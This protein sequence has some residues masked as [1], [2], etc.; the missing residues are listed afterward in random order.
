[1]KHNFISLTPNPPEG[2]NNITPSKHDLLGGRVAI[3]TDSVEDATSLLDN[4]TERIQGIIITQGERFFFTAMGPALWYMGVPGYMLADLASIAAGYLDVLSYGQSALSEN[5]QLKLELAHSEEVQSQLTE[6]YNKNIQRLGKKVDQ[7]HEEME[8]SRQAEDALRL[9][10]FSIEHASDALFWMTSDGR[11]VDVNEA[12]CRTLGYTR[13]E[14]MQLTM[15]D[16][17]PHNQAEQWSRH[18]AELR[19]RGSLQ[20]ESEQRTKDGRLIPVEIVANHVQFGAEERNCAFVRDTTE[21]KL[22][23]QKLHYLQNYLSN[24]INSMPSALIGVDTDGRVTQWNSR[25]QRI[26]GVSSEDAATQPLG[27]IFPRLEKDMKQVVEAMRTRQ[28]RQN[29]KRLHQTKSNIGYEDITIY[30][31]IA[32]GVDGAVIRIDDVTEQVRQEEMLVQSEKMLS[33]GGLAA[34]MAHEINNPLAGIIQTAAVMKSRLQDLEME[35]NIRVANEIGIPMGN[36]RAF[37]DKRNVFSMVD[38]ISEACQRVAKIVDNMLSFAR[39]SDA[40]VSI[41]DPVQLIDQVIELASADYDLKKQYD[42]KAIKIVKEYE[43]N[44]PMVP[45]EGPKIQQ[46]LLNILGNG[47]QAMHSKFTKEAD[48]CFI[49]RLS[50]EKEKCVLKIEIEDNGPGMDKSTQTRIFEPFF[51]TKPVGEGTGLGLSVS[52]FIITQ[53]H[54]GTMDVASTP[55]KGST[56]I[57]C[58]PLAQK[59]RDKE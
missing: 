53:N 6:N 15:A 19:L 25:A 42:F 55:S 59:K 28:V 29:K 31:L 49:L 18:F 2:F 10:R 36:I 30:P 5:E 12:A 54:G 21:R 33:V 14:L 24:I 22:A 43:E 13:Q 37:M 57:I 23:E 39:K 7:L 1:M 8:R 48:P 51:T 58:L 17:D 27:K 45:C 56:F 50:V 35:A 26:T 9:T 38:S 11:I 16:V 47:A 20:Y 41:H 44:L 46:V 4:F 32:N 40:R 52:Y 34:G 3:Y